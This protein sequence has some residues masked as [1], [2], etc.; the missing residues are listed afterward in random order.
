MA[1]PQRSGI[2][3]TPTDVDRV[4]GAD[5]AVRW[6]E[7]SLKG[8]RDKSELMAKA[9]KAFA[10]PATFGANWDALADALQ[11]VSCP[12]EKGCLLR[13]TDSGLSTLPETDREILL[14]VLARS[15]A[16]WR[17]QGKAFV[18]LIDGADRLPLWT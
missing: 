17:G 16:Y 4:R 2:Y 13:I 3:R 1:D 6:V 11:D 8:V 5:A 12:G 18:V 10:F 14:E 15:A 9:A 7:L